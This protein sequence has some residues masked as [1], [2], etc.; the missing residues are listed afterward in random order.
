[1]KWI[2]LLLLV[3]AGAWAYFN[4]DFSQLESNAENAV[5]NEKT[6][7][8]FFESDQQGKDQLNKTIQ[9]NF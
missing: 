1:M 5:R 9:E 7:K 2:I 6:I 8:K 4:V 3:A